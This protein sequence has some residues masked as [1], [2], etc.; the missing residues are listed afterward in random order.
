MSK[1]T[2]EIEDMADGSVRVNASS[3][4]FGVTSD[5]LPSKAAKVSSSVMTLVD[6]INGENN[7]N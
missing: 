2:I 5:S 1:I 3:D 7:D 4:Q 6:Y